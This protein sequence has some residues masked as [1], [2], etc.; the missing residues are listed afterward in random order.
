MPS[1]E[2]VN[3]LTA[4]KVK[5]PDLGKKRAAIGRL[6]KLTGR[7]QT[8]WTSHSHPEDWINLKLAQTF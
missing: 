7:R 1:G 4:E 2:I 5:P 6:R 8:E 3:R